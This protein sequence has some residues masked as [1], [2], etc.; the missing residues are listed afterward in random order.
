MNE[1][2]RSLY[3]TATGVLFVCAALVLLFV[4]IGRY[5]RTFDGGRQASLRSALLASVAN[6]DE[7]VAAVQ[8]ASAELGIDKYG[9]G[10]L[11]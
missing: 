9:I 6:E 10:I 1:Q 7:L 3:N 5:V 2:R 11:N 8:G 4:S